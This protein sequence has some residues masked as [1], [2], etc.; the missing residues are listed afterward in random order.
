M[1]LSPDLIC[2]CVDGIIERINA[3]GMGMLRAPSDAA[4]IGKPLLHFVQ[5]DYRALFDAGLEALYGED[6]PVPI[7]I[8]TFAGRVRDLELSA[9]PLRRDGHTATLVVGRDTTEVTAA[10]R[11]VAAREHR[12]RA[13]M[14]TVLDGIITIDEDGTIL[15]A[16]LSVER[17]FG[18]PL[19]ELI[20]SN[21]AALMPEPDASRHGSY[22]RCFL[23]G[24]GGPSS[25]SAARS[26]ASAGA[27]P[28]PR[29]TCRCPSC[30][31]T[32]AACS[33][34]PSATSA[35]TRRWPSGW[36]TSP[37]TTR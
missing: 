24:G 13:I 16:N 30:A 5:P 1:E 26:P 4:C 27:T 15:N 18:H 25:A 34:A 14:D 31:W 2:V 23:A 7:K 17:I 6:H 8:V 3:A 32:S 9:V 10:M 19:S 11:A 28:V 29:C 33:P 22:I 37:T 36:P 35:R 12:I 20:G 21:V